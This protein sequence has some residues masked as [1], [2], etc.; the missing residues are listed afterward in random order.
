M[1]N[2]RVGLFIALLAGVTGAAC[3]T[4]STTS[5]APSTVPRC[6]V[7]LGETELSVPASGGS[8]TINVTTARECAWTANS[9]ASWLTFRG[10]SNGQGDGKVEYVA[11]ANGD[12]S[13]RRGVIELNDQHANVTQAAADCVMQLGDSSESFSQSGGSGTIAVQASGPRLR[14][15]G[16]LRF[17]LDCHQVR[18][19]RHRERNRGVRRASRF[20]TAARRNRARRRSA[21]LDH[22]IGELHL[23]RFA[24][25]LFDRIGGRLDDNCRDDQRRLPVDCG[26]QR[27]LGDGRA[28]IERYRFRERADRRRSHEW[29]YEVGHGGGGRSGRDR[30]TVGWLQLQRRSAVAIVQLAGRH[31]LRIDRGRRRLRVDGLEQRALDYAHR[32]IVRQRKRVDRL[33]GCRAER[34]RANWHDQRGGHANHDHAG[35]RMRHLDCADVGQCPRGRRH[36]QRGGDDGCRVPLDGSEQRILADGH[37]RG[38][39]QR[40][41]H[42]AVQRG[43]Y[44][45]ASRDPPRSPS[46]VRRSPSIRRV[47]ARFRWPRRAPAWRP[48][49]PRTP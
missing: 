26:Q 5:T 46:A 31:R 32:P 48:E 3:G 1:T 25:E 29:S 28:G 49:E 19:E 2:L 39:R 45:E 42:R 16:G 37:V 22:A 47:D 20:G 9:T 4:S 8:G 6:G 13:S 33:Y 30:D 44:G 40:K 43:R 14:V 36:G 34:S 12:P 21:L 17:E 35:Q 11:A 10:S 27:A 23:R 7:S 41:R 15:D 38:E 24:H 18:R